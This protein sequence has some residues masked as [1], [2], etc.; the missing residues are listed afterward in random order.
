MV[1]I[2]WDGRVRL[3]EKRRWLI[4]LPLALAFIIV[5]FHRFA[6]GVVSDSIMRDFGLARAAELGLLSSIYFYTYAVLQVPTGVSADYWGPRRTIT[7]A[8]VVA[9]AGTFIFGWAPSLTWLYIG[10]FITSAGIAFIYINIVK[11]YASWFRSREFGTMSGMSS[12]IGNLGFALAAT[13]LAMMVE[14]TGW[15]ESFYIV[16][17]ITLLVAVYC[18]LTV[19]NTPVDYGWPSIEEI[20]A[21]EGAG[22]AAGGDSDSKCTVMESLRTVIA[23]R[24]TWPPCLASTASY[25]VFATFA[26]VWGMPYLMQ[27]HGLPRI[28]AAGYMVAI[29]VGYMTAG[30]LVGYLSDRFATRRWP[31]VAQ[32]TILLVAWLVLTAWDGGKPPAAALYPLCLALGVGASG[33]T[34][35]LACAKEVNPP[36]M[37]GIATGLVN[38]GPFIGAALV[39]PLF[40]LVLDLKWQGAVEQGVKIYPLEAFQTAFWLCAVLV[41]VAVAAALCIKETRCVNIA[42]RVIG[43]SD[44]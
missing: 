7:A 23:N 1:N 28:E 31:F 29:S 11:F 39:Q 13:P 16:G 41:A 6:M 32:M 22:P 24:H 10:R 19:R 17:I 12:F 36:H 38:M 37:T 5:Y 27:I 4:C 35:T 34:L 40:G 2:P 14:N 33:I 43:G 9:A 42:R 44:L 25:S 26:G 3:V 21:A 15:R 8:L 20:E 30:P 18:W